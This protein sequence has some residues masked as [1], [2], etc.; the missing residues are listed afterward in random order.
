MNFC[1]GRFVIIGMASTQS[2]NAVNRDEVAIIIQHR[3]IIKH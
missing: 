2:R 1:R 3:T